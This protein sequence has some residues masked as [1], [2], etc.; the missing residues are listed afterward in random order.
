MAVTLTGFHW[1]HRAAECKA[2]AKRTNINLL[3]GLTEFWLQRDQQWRSD[4]LLDHL[5]S[6]GCMELGLT[7]MTLA[8][9]PG[10]AQEVVL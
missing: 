5:S 3:Q 7:P 1:A 10:Q 4:L 8:E 9:V 6:N 2:C